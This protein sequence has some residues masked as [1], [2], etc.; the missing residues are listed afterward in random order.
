MSSE[1]YLMKYP[2]DFK[3]WKPLG[4]ILGNRYMVIEDPKRE[5]QALIH[6]IDHDVCE[7]KEMR[8][9]ETVYSHPLNPLVAR[10]ILYSISMEEAAKQYFAK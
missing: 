2:D 1:A 4:F 8:T 5:Y 10:M 7:V 3:G 9:G 6:L